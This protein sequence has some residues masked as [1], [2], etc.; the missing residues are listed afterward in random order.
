MAKQNRTIERA[1]NVIQK[2]IETLA[3]K[4]DEAKERYPYELYGLRYME[5]T[6]KYETEIE[7]LKKY[8]EGQMFARAQLEQDKEMKRELFRAKMTIQDAIS[9]LKQYGEI[10][11]AE[12]LERHLSEVNE[13]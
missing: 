7:E 11:L 10:N 6:A 13:I 2:R 5:K 1:E 3:R 12:R 8:L 4:I 9:A